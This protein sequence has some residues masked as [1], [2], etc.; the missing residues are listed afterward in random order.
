LDI[1]IQYV[2]SRDQATTDNRSYELKLTSQQNNNVGYDK[3]KWV[4]FTYSP[5]FGKVTNVFQDSSLQIALKPTNTV[6]H[7]TKEQDSTH[8]ELRRESGV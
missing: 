2:V 8:I 6:S 7:L 1:I 4:T 3:Q 5:L